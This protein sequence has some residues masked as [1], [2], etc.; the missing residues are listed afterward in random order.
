MQAIVNAARDGQLDAQVAAAILTREDSPAAEALRGLGTRVLFVYPGDGYE[1]RLHGVIAEL[2]PT[3]IC[4]CGYMR[5][6]PLRI[7]EAYPH[8]ILNIHPALLPRHGGKGM[9]GLAVH[10]AVLSAGDME[11]GCT[12][13]FVSEEYD[14]GEIVLQQRVAVE[15]GDT[16]EAL[17]ARVLPLEHETY[18]RAIAIVLAANPPTSADWS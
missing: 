1:E 4:L 10:Q 5:K 13:H 18:V 3:L 11:T 6:L 14:E 15:P 2:S 9:Y 8:G 12:V 7:V 16:A 17:A